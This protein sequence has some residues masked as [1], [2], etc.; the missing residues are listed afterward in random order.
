MISVI[1]IKTFSSWIQSAQYNYWNFF[2]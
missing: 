2:V 1:Y